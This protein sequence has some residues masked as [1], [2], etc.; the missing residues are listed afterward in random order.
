ML[1]LPGTG[2]HTG[3]DAGTTSQKRDK[4]RQTGESG[5]PTIDSLLLTISP[6]LVVHRNGQHDVNPGT[7]NCREF[8]NCACQEDGGLLL[9]G[10]DS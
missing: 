2:F 5:K 3:W 4:P 9:D 1:S 7:P 6:L 10:L 8:T